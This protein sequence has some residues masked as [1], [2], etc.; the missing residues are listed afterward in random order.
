[1]KIWK[2]LDNYRCNMGHKKLF[3]LLFVVCS[4]ISNDLVHAKQKERFK[5]TEIRVIRPSYFNKAK[6]FELGAGMNMVMN[7]SFI[8][9]FLLLGLQHITSQKHGL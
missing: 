1:M 5:D 4:I 3:I 9:T 2:N 6:R 7:E 8:Y